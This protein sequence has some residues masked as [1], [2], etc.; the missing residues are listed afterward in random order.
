MYIT[1]FEKV[2]IY[3]LL[4]LGYVATFA[5]V[6]LMFI[7]IFNR[8][9][10]IYRKYILDESYRPKFSVIIP[11]HNEENVIERTIK[12]FLNT[13]YLPNKKELILVNDGSTDNTKELAAKYAYKI[14]CSETG[15]CETKEGYGNIILINRSVGGKGKSHVLNDGRHFTNNEILLIIDADVQ[16]GNNIFELAAKHFSDKRVGAVAGYISISEKKGFM[17]N[18]FV[19]FECVVAQK[20]MRLGF[21]TLGIHY[22]IPGGCGFFR[23]DIIDKIGDYESDTLAEDTDMTWRLMTETGTKIHFDPSIRVEADEPI[24]LNSLWNQRVRWARGNFGVTRKHIHKIGKRVYGKAATL[25]YPFWIATVI[26]PLTFLTTILGLLLNGIFNVDISMI[27]VFGRI[28][29]FMFISIW[30]I[31]VIINKGK[32]WFAGLIS[33]GIPMLITMFATIW[34]N[35]I[36]GSMVKIGYPEYTGIMNLLLLSWIIISFILTPSVV[37]LSKKHSKIANM[38]QIGLFGYWIILVTSGL[39]GYFKELKKDELIWIRTVR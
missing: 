27:P 33:P 17:L 16:L 38:I 4:T 28:M 3:S 6:F 29:S 23:K 19:D 1:I 39:Y 12:S 37:M 9:R 24:S 5:T 11:A 10:Y 20:V 31:G 15:K 35:G 36:E 8:L 26:I 30:I 22:I 32:S 18:S 25:G 7:T 14:I 34:Q 21:D 2:L 13:S